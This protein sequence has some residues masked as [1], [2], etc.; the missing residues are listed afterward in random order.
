[1]KRLIS[2][3]LIISISTFSIG[4]DSCKKKTSNSNTMVE[5]TEQKIARFKRIAAENR[6]KIENALTQIVIFKRELSAAGK[7]SKDTDNK[8]TLSLAKINDETERIGNL[9]ANIKSLSGLDEAVTIIRE[10]D[11]EF[12]ITQKYLGEN[13]E[14]MSA[15]FDIVRNSITILKSLIS[16]IKK[17]I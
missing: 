3:L 14:A 1:M 17:E 4:A 5:T 16:D 2:L 6:H 12:N 9:I 11:N 8:L 10:I 15:V 13:F 7:L